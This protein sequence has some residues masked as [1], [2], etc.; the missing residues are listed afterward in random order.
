MVLQQ[1]PQENPEAG[2]VASVC[3]NTRRSNTLNQTLA[4]AKPR[5]EMKPPPKSV[6]H[7]LLRPRLS[8]AALMCCFMVASAPVLESTPLILGT[9]GGNIIFPGSVVLIRLSNWVSLIVLLC[10]APSGLADQVAWQHIYPVCPPQHQCA[11]ILAVRDPAARCCPSLV[12]SGIT[13]LRLF[14]VSAFVL[15]VDVGH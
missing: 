7:H 4:P 8:G 3:V 5:E 10:E 1:F 2:N 15:E 6:C 12:I 14:Q 9:R 11:D 13:T